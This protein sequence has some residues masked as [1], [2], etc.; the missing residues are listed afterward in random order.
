MG[1]QPTNPATPSTPKPR[2]AVFSSNTQPVAHRPTGSWSKTWTFPRISNLQTAQLHNKQDSVDKFFGCL[3]DE[4]SSEGGSSPCS[5][6]QYSFEKSKSL[7][8]NALRD[9]DEDESPFFSPQGVRSITEKKHLNTVPEDDEE[10]DETS[11]DNESDAD[12][13]GEMGGIRITLSP[14]Q[15]EDDEFVIEPPQL[16][17]QAIP[18]PV[19]RPPQLP[20]LNF[21]DD[22]D[23]DDAGFNFGRALE[24]SHFEEVEGVKEGA[25]V[26]P[27]VVSAPPAI[28]VSPPPAVEVSPPVTIATP[29]VAQ[30]PPSSTI[31]HSTSPR[32]TSSSCIPR[33]L[34]RPDVRAESPKTITTASSSVTGVYTTPSKRDGN[35]A[36]FIPQPVSSPSPICTAP[37]SGKPRPPRASTFIRQPQ[38]KLHI[39][40]TAETINRSGTSSIGSNPTSQIA[41][42]T[43]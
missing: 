16:I 35:T 8:V 14:P 25:T 5:P 15:P 3:E 7:F 39:G 24:S 19:E 13:F 26:A 20:M 30:T 9:A 31:L 10:E 43:Y 12:M 32:S 42:R 37:S 36:S 33:F 41:I 6:S 38:R 11:E 21:G 34:L 2:N 29:A 27:A 23:E 17:V 22:E 18:R 4:G 28:V 40:N 1:E